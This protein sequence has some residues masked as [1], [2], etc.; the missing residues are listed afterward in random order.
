[1]NKI[2]EIV[3]MAVGGLS[4]FLV[5]FVGFASMS[6]RDVSKVA[7]IGKLFPPPAETAGEHGESGGEHA[8]AG[9]SGEHDE[10]EG[11]EETLSD[12]AVIEASLGVLSAWTL[13]S[14]Y[15]TSELRVL[16]EEIKKKHAELEERELSLGRRERAV[17]EDEHELEERLKTLEEL[18]THLESMQTELTEKESELARQESS[19]EAGKDAR[20]AQVA[21]VIGGIEEPAAAAKKLQEFPAEDAAKILR[22]LG[23]EARASEILNQVDQARWKSYVDAYTF[24]K[25]RAGKSKKK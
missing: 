24:E 13:P 21:L 16:S 19:L 6:G 7:L 8:P 23:D 4:L 20:W 15:S 12:S 25:A 17:S 5:A 3:A 22:A 1:M 2:I 10:Q 14:P 9:E 18:R 11:H